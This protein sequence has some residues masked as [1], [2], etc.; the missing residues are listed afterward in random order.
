[1]CIEKRLVVDLVAL[2][3]MVYDEAAFWS[4]RLPGEKTLR[5]LPTT[6][7]LADVLTKVVVD[8]KGWWAQIRT[9]NLPFATSASST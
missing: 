1:M 6:S 2:R 9:T 8:I 7:Q 4:K 3:K 5:W